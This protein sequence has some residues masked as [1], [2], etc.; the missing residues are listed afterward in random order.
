MTFVPYAGMAPAVNELLGEHV[1]AMS[2]TYSNV[3]EH[4][5]AGKL[6]ALAVT[7]PNRIEMLP[8]VPTIAESGHKDHEVDAWYASFAPQK[9]SHQMVTQ[10]VGW[11]R[12]ATEAPEVKAKLA[13]QGLYPVGKCGTEFGDYLRKQYDEYGRVIRESNIKAE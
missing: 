3:A 2:S 8:D 13:I 11:C 1:T 9:T 12:A 6:R 5:K 10:L 4:M 7:T